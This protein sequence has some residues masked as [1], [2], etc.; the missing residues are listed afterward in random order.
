MGTVLDAY[1]VIAFVGEEPTAE[2]VE[3]LLRSGEAAIAA[4]NLAEAL[5]VLERRDRVPEDALRALLE[6][7]PLAVLPVDETL[8]WRA[9]RLRARHYHRRRRRVS[10]AD[11]V[12]V[13]AAGPGDAIATGDRSVIE[14]AVEEGV[15]TVP[16]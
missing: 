4:V 16:L 15:E 14:M 13:A 7:L 12:L 5:D 1:A 9:A 2:K 11:C 3:H 6:P 8:A 10:V